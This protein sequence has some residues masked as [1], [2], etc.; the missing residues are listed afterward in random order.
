MELEQ[1]NW[2]FSI[3]LR[4]KQQICIP[5][6]SNFGE[7]VMVVEKMAWFWDSHE[8][9]HEEKQK[10]GDVLVA[11]WAGRRSRRDFRRHNEW[12][13]GQQA[14]VR[15]RVESNGQGRMF[16]INQF[17]LE[18]ELNTVCEGLSSAHRELYKQLIRA[19]AWWLLKNWFKGELSLSW[20]SFPPEKIYILESGL[21][22]V[23]MC[24]LYVLVQC[25]SKMIWRFPGFL[26][27]DF[28]TQSK[29][30]LP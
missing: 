7:V 13:P 30:G 3:F 8:F 1:L 4:N 15:A 27:L 19:E 10:I 6:G 12:R 9:S 28:G 25:S 24:N 23:L 14:S 22:L 20:L 18:L 11:K 16:V 17:V 26:G 2:Y 21:T 5:L 29:T